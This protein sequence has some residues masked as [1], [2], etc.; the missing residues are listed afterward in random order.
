LRQLRAFL[1][2]AQELSFS[3]AAERLVVST[4]WISETVKELERQLKVTLFLRTTRSVELTDAGR[5][6]S[7]LLAHVLDDLD[8]AVR[9]AQRTAA[10]SGRALTLG[11]VIGAGLELM[12][13]LVRCAARNTTSPTP[14]PACAITTWTR[15]SC[16]RRWAWRGSPRSS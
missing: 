9:V 12:P 4:P 2:V 5:V 11:Y 16:G 7:G 3:R 8:D 15:R 1:A 13:R 10:R 6:F 14:R